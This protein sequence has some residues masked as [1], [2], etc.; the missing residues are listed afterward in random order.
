P[1]SAWIVA[2]DLLPDGSTEPAAPSV[3]DPPSGP[4]PPAAPVPPGLPPLV[5]PPS[6]DGD[7]LQIA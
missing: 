5:T 7:P 4:V 2:P 1:W 3:P 6:A